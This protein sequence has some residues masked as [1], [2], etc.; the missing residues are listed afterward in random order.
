LAAPGPRGI[1]QLL[2]KPP[3]RLQRATARFRAAAERG[4]GTTLRHRLGV[5]H[6]L[7]VRSNAGNAFLTRLNAMRGSARAQWTRTYAAPLPTGFGYLAARITLSIPQLPAYPLVEFAEHVADE[8]GRAT[9]TVLATFPRGFALSND[10]GVN[11]EYVRIRGWRDHRV[12]H[13][14]AIGRGE[15]LIQAVPSRPYPSQLRSI[16]LLVV[17]QSGRV[18]AANRL[19][20]SRW[21]GCRS[22]DIAGDTLMY[23][24]YPYDSDDPFS[25]ER[26]ESRVFRSRDRGRSWEIV[27]RE[28]TVR[29]FHLLQAR[30]GT[31]GE[32]WLTSGDEPGECHIWVSRDDGDSWTSLT[33]SFGDSI[34]I[35]NER[36]RRTLFRLT[37]LAWQENEVVWGTDDC[38]RA[39]GVRGA[40]V[41][42]SPAAPPLLPEIAGRTPWEIRSLVDIGEAYIFLTQGC[43]RPDN[44]RNDGPG[45]YLMPKRPGGE[46]A[47]LFDIAVHSTIRTGFTYSRASRAAK[48]GVFFTFRTSTDAFP[49]GHKI[50]KWEVSLA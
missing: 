2:S 44:G 13:V 19:E 20:G 37:D 43:A 16:A 4:G 31:R 25:K 33:D 22:V 8:S 48:D 5:L 39:A 3:N 45:V 32:W 40:R 41:V 10:L 30:P 27:R 11:W 47:H 34:A 12:I 42:R 23:A 50:L 46:L 49:F 9:D 36:F 14:K 7:F 1:A 29:H 35:G 17:D 28:N 21:H 6:G 26:F 38:L 24:E 18:L 15:F